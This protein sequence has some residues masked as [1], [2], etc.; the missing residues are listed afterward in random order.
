MARHSLN[1][2]HYASVILQRELTIPAISC[3]KKW[4]ASPGSIPWSGSIKKQKGVCNGREHVKR[5][6]TDLILQCHEYKY[7]CICTYPVKE[8]STISILK[9]EVVSASHGPLT[10]EPDHIL[11]TKHFHDANLCKTNIN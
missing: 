7:L 2:I 10:K 8:L 6:Y 5:Q 11:T 9:E 4:C 3:K 1:T